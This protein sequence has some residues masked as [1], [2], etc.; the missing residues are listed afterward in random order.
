MKIK[1]VDFAFYCVSDLKKSVDFYQ[2]TLG[3]N[4]KSQG[5]TWAEFDIGNLCLDIGVFGKPGGS[6]AGIALAV[7]DV[8][9]AL[10]EL[11]KK[12]VKVEEETW[13]TPVCHGGTIEDP[14]GNKISLHTRKDGTCG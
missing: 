4:L 3:L 8:K 1:A 14:D 7:D 11:K 9:S 2:K 10:A 13:E 5:D 6:S 12:G